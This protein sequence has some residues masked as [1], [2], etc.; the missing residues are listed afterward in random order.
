MGGPGILHGAFEGT[1]GGHSVHEGKQDAQSTEG[2]QTA[3]PS[4]TIQKGLQDKHIAGTKNYKQE[5][6]KG[7]HPSV[8][9]GDAGTLLTEGVGKGHKQGDTKEVIDY[10][11]VIGKF[12]D[13]D[14]KKYYDTTRAT[15][16]FDSKNKAHIVPAKPKE[17]LKKGENNG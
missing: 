16:H 13:L 3:R 12:Y 7:E 1:Q 5:I 8:L 14:T 4:T 11:R 15:I 10:G 9:T 2:K 17:F 6:A